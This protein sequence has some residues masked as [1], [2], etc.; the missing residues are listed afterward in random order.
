MKSFFDKM[1]K[2]GLFKADL[3]YKKSYTLQFVN[4]GVGLGHQE[5]LSALARPPSRGGAEQVVSIAWASSPTG[6]ARARRS[7]TLRTR[8]TRSCRCSR[9]RSTA[10]RAAARPSSPC[11]ASGKPSPTARPRSPASTSTSGRA[12]SSPFSAPPAAASRRRCASWRA[13]PSR[14]GGAVEWPGSRAGEDHRGEIGFVFQEPTL[15]PW[16]DAADNVW[17][18]LAPAR[19]LP[20]RGRA[21][22]RRGPRPRRP[23]R[24]RARLSARALGR[25]EDARLHRPRPVAQAQAA[26]HGRALRGARRDHPLQA[27][28]R[29]AGASARDRL[30]GGLRHPLGLRERLSVEPRRGH[31]GASRAGG[32][33][34]RGGG[35]GEPRRPLPHRSALSRPLPAGE[36]GPDGRDPR[37]A[38]S[39][40]EER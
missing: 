38:S 21:P 17:L 31:G 19:R 12:S 23:V 7:C 8:L 10:P 37:P 16:A 11:A 13:S 28:R 25:H 27:Q 3:D 30:H 4:K 9:R 15:M 36:R 33:G 35:P 26:P 2:A 5:E 20:P 1:V 22:H 6:A 14:R 40:T 39:R 32:G 29:P 18:P 24:L 34:D